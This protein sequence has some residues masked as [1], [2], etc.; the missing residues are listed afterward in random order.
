M[1]FA[2]LAVLL[3]LPPFVHVAFGSSSMALGLIFASLFILI[4]NKKYL[5]LNTLSSRFI[6]YILGFAF[7]LFTSASYSYFSYGLS[8]PLFSLILFLPLFA[9][10]ILAKSIAKFPFKK[11]Y[12]S[13][14]SIVILFL[15]LGFISVFYTPEYFGYRLYEKPVFPFSEQSHYALALGLISVAY[16]LVSPLKQLFALG[17]IM[18]SLALIFPN[19]TLLIFAIVIFLTAIFRLPPKIFKTL[20]LLSPFV[21]IGL[22]L[23]ISQIEYFASRLAFENTKNISVLIFLQGWDFA[24]ENTLNTHGLGLGFQM[25][26]SPLSALSEYSQKV[27]ELSTHQLNF[28]DGSFLASKLI[29]EFGIFGII[30]LIGYL[31]FMLKMLFI[32]NGLYHQ[33]DK[34]EEHRQKHLLLLGIIFAFFIEIFLRGYGYFSSGLFLFASAF[35]A[36]YTFNTHKKEN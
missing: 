3:L 24:Y 7:L 35:F 36:L 31:V 29:S 9:S 4:L 28:Y 26:G 22:F 27:Y 17:L 8:K 6:C 11:I 21:F 32:A 30:A 16:A 15:S 34:N 14:Q 2:S 33:K 25:L 20:L 10:L 13:L 12:Q 1:L 19:L 5:Y 18:T 23:L